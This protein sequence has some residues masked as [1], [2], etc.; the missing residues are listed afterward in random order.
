MELAPLLEIGAA[1][2]ALT[3]AQQ[4]AVR[5]LD[6]YDP[7]DVDLG[8][9]LA[10]LADA[11]TLTPEDVRPVMDYLTCVVR[12]AQETND[13]DLGDEATELAWRVGV[14]ASDVAY[15]DIKDGE[16]FDLIG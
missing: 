15:L 13:D 12:L 9:H 6:D 7:D 4:A 11:G 10:I 5:D 14:W 8:E 1:F 3:P 2:A 16:G